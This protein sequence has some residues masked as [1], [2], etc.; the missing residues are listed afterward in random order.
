M[1]GTDDITVRPLFFVTKK[2]LSVNAVI[3]CQWG[4]PITITGME[5][6]L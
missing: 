1:K 6:Q 2:F 5:I 4:C 3:I